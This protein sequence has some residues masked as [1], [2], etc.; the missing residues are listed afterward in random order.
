[1]TIALHQYR[2]VDTD[3]LFK[4]VEDIFRRYEGRPHWG[5]RHTRTA[6]E[7]AQIYPAYERFRQLRAKLDPQG[8]FL[9]RYLKSLFG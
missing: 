4:P 3:K 1:V 6:G 2:R 5:K 8:K 7:L 9:N